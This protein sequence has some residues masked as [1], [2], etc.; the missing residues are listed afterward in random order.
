MVKNVEKFV[1]TVKIEKNLVELVAN[2]QKW[3][4]MVR[5]WSLIGLEGCKKYCK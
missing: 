4:Q 3:S 5:K 1:K 2:G